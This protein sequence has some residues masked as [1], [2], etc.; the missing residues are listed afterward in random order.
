MTITGHAH[1]SNLYAEQAAYFSERARFLYERNFPASAK[2][3][4]EM[5]DNSYFLAMKYRQIAQ[6]LERRARED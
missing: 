1:V 4:Q 3:Y 6:Q 5:A 2:E